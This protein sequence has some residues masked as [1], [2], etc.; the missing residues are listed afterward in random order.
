[1]NTQ[2]QLRVYNQ[3]GTKMFEQTSNSVPQIG[4]HVVVR[5]HMFKVTQVVYCDIQTILL[6]VKSGIL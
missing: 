5:N 4:E 1:M 6:V 2:F 3:S